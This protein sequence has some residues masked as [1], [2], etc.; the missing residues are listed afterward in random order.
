MLRDPKRQKYHEPFRLKSLLRL[1]GRLCMLVQVIECTSI[2]RWH[3]HD[4]N[5]VNAFVRRCDT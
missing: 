2:N 1:G 4:L 3:S 5:P